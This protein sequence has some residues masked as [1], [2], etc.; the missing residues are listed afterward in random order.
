MFSHFR[1]FLIFRAKEQRVK[2][3]LLP[4]TLAFPLRGPCGRLYRRSSRE[5]IF[6]I[7]ILY[8]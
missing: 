1:R 3:F 4:R 8:W 5:L 2:D 6:V 7:R